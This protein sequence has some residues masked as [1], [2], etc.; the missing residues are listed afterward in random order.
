MEWSDAF[1]ARFRHGPSHPCGNGTSISETPAGCNSLRYGEE[2]G[3][4]RRLL[5]RSRRIELFR[6]MF[7]FMNRPRDMVHAG[8]PQVDRLLQARH[9]HDIIRHAREDACTRTRNQ[10]TSSSLVRHAASVIYV[11]IHFPVAVTIRAAAQ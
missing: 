1:L 11:N 7:L 4:F 9:A 8:M 10:S 5:W 3:A 6:W 2:V